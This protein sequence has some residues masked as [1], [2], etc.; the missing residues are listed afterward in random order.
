MGRGRLITGLLL[1]VLASCGPLNPHMEYTEFSL[2]EHP[3]AISGMQAPKQ[4]QELIR[5]HYDRGGDEEMLITDLI[6]DGTTLKMVF[7]SG[8]YRIIHYVMENGVARFDRP[9]FYA[10]YDGEDVL[11]CK[12]RYETIKNF[13]Y[14]GINFDGMRSVTFYDPSLSNPDNV[15]IDRGEWRFNIVEMQAPTNEALYQIEGRYGHNV[16]SDPRYPDGPSWSWGFLRDGELFPRETSLDLATIYGGPQWR[17]PTW[18]EAVALLS[19]HSVNYARFA[20]T[21]RVCAYIENADKQ[22]AAFDVKDGSSE[23]GFWLAGGA[24][25]IFTVDRD[26]HTASALITEDTSGKELLIWPVKD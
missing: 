16:S 2:T 5:T 9:L 21:G 4:M 14:G 1:F 11:T 25:V 6:F 24:A 8:A 20:D 10:S 7:P 15:K 12:Y 23:V 18:D 13:S 3:W 19:S 17:L 26:A 22:Q